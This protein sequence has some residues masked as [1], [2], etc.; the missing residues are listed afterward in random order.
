MLL[1][2]LTIKHVSHTKGQECKSNKKN[3]KRIYKRKSEWI[4]KLPVSDWRHFEI[5]FK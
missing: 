1:S 5:T 4:K 3:Q 2:I